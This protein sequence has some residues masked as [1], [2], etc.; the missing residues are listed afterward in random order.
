[1]VHMPTL[2]DMQE[3]EEHMHGKRNFRK[4]FSMMAGFTTQHVQYLVL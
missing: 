4:G 3:A 1:M 2:N